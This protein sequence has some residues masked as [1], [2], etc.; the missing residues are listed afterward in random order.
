MF[1]MT[2]IFSN[3][4]KSFEKSIEELQKR[5]LISN[6]KT[7]N[8]VSLIKVVLL[9]HSELKDSVLSENSVFIWQTVNALFVVRTVVK[10]MV[11]RI[12]DEVR[13]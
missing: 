5:F 8:F 9:R 12:K 3:E 6:L 4:W 11:E 7:G 1:D 2:S 13:G 10:F